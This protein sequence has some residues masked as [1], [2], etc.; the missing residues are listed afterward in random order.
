MIEAFVEEQNSIMTS[1]LKLFEEELEIYE[2]QERTQA[3]KSLQTLQEEKD[4]LLT[5]R[6]RIMQ[7]KI[8][9]V[10]DDKKEQQAIIESHNEDTQRLIN[11]ID[12][13]KLRMEADLQERIK[14]RKKAKLKIKEAQLQKNMIRVVN[15]MAV[16]DQNEMAELAESEVKVLHQSVDSQKFSL[17]DDEGFSISGTAVKTQ[18][19]EPS[20]DDIFL[21]LNDI[22]TLLHSSS[23]LS[24]QNIGQQWYIDAKEDEWISDTT[25]HPLDTSSISAREFV[26]YKFGCYIINSLVTHCNY[27]PVSL[28]I[29]DK[30]PPNQWNYNSF[31]NSY[32][33][34][35]HN[36]ILYMRLERLNNIGEF[37]LVLAHALS[38][39]K[40][41]ASFMDYDHVFIR[42][43]YTC[44]SVCF[45]DLFLS[46]Y[47]ASPIDTKGTEISV[48][49]PWDCIVNEI[50]DTKVLVSVDVDGYKF[51]HQHIMERLQNYG[52]FRVGTVLR[53]YLDSME[54]PVGSDKLD[55]HVE[56]KV[57]LSGELSQSLANFATKKRWQAAVSKKKAFN[58][59]RDQYI[60]YLKIQINDIRERID[61]LNDE[62]TQITK[63]K[64]SATETLQR[65]KNKLISY[66]NDL[67]SLKDE[68]QDFIIK[69]VLIK[70]CTVKLNTV[71]TDLAKLDF[72]SNGCIQRLNVFKSQLDEK[73]LILTDFINQK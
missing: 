21:K 28:L 58:K 63:G 23:V 69:K 25:F 48:K 10:Q 1:E 3:K 30:I 43:F 67:K 72:R 56:N 24:T 57:V 13:Q 11:K 32:S 62:Y 2:V 22:R 47:W 42:E 33:Y 65:L 20:S 29:A 7:D 49:T 53:N 38:H 37:I 66:Q 41:G 64:L 5:E 73:L 60:H 34:D 55:S 52:R 19:C 40:A 31:L 46:R 18:P 27:S 16:N 45:S 61:K 4:F 15:E 36:K 9:S 51:G 39:I 6:K 14:E 35:S 44:L 59:E 12:T 26:A 54:E 71:Q 70:D 68:T 17:H 50:V 8:N